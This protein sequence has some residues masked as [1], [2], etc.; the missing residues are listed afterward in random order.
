MTQ[1]EVLISVKGPSGTFSQTEAGRIPPQSKPEWIKLDGNTDYE[2]L[3]KLLINATAT[4]VMAME[5]ANTTWGD[6]LREKR[7]QMRD[8]LNNLLKYL[9]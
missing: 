3:H 6:R 5:G 2:L 7:E 9:S 4:Y 1:I 8:F